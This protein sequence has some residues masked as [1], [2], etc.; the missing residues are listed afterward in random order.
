MIYENAT[1]LRGENHAWEVQNYTKKE[2]RQTSFWEMGYGTCVQI[3]VLE[4]IFVKKKFAERVLLFAHLLF[5][6]KLA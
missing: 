3:V 1:G 5:N 6:S 2:A 4:L